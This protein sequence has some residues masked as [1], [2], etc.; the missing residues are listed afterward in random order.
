MLHTSGRK[1]R[2]LTV[3]TNFSFMVFFTIFKNHVNGL[4]N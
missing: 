4:Y 2:G 1:L 3:L